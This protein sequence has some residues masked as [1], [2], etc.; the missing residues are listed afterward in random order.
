MLEGFV[1]SPLGNQSGFL[2]TYQTF[3]NCVRPFFENHSENNTLVPH[4]HPLARGPI[5][6]LDHPNFLFGCSFAVNDLNKQSLPRNTLF[7]KIELR[8]LVCFSWATAMNNC[9]K[10]SIQK[11]EKPFLFVILVTSK[12]CHAIPGTKMKK[13]KNDTKASQNATTSAFA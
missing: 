11:D 4:D 2:K 3:Y 8:L 1:Q 12:Q 5:D 9:L 6:A 10:F 13:Y 7:F